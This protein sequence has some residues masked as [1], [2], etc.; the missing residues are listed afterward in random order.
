MNGHWNLYQRL[1]FRLEIWLDSTKPILTIGKFSNCS[2]FGSPSKLQVM[3][4]GWHRVNPCNDSKIPCQAPSRSEYSHPA[5]LRRAWFHQW[6][7]SHSNDSIDRC[8]GRN[9]VG[10]ENCHRSAVSPEVWNHCKGQRLRMIR[11]I[12]VAALWRYQGVVT[13]VRHVNLSLFEHFCLSRLE[14]D[15]GYRLRSADLIEQCSQVDVMMCSTEISR[16]EIDEGKLFSPIIAV[17]SDGRVAVPKR[18]RRSWSEGKV[19]GEPKRK[20]R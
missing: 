17:F 3:Y 4:S 6:Y 10:L 19:N 5:R 16:I 15:N 20:R 11:V 18:S 14:T 1:Y 2:I 9:W 8:G 12:E 7:S 13:L